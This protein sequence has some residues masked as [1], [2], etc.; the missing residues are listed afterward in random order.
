MHLSQHFRQHDDSAIDAQRRRRWNRTHRDMA[1]H[2]PSRATI[3]ER[4]TSASVRQQRSRPTSTAVPSPTAETNSRSN[5]QT[6]TA[7][8]TTTTDTT[9]RDVLTR[10]ALIKRTTIS[11]T[12][13]PDRNG[14]FRRSVEADRSKSQTKTQAKPRSDSVAGM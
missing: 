1:S 12:K 8:T 9:R 4:R 14:S 3:A 11:P 13:P 7:T 10:E 2:L 6:R 5:N